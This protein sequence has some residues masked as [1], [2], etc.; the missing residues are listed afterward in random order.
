MATATLAS[1]PTVID[2]AEAITN[3]GGDTFALN[4][5]SFIQGNSSVECAMT[6]NG[7]NDIYVTGSW[8]FSTTDQHLRLWFNITFV[9]NLSATDPIQIFL[10][11]GTNTAYYYWDKFAEY[12][13]GWAQAVIFTGATP[14]SGTVTKSSITRIGMRFAT[15]SKPRNVPY[16]ALFDAWTYGDGYTVYGGTNGDPI[17]WS[18]IATADATNAYGIVDELNGVYF[19]RGAIQIGDGTNTTYFEPAGQLGVFVDEQIE[20]GLYG[21]TFVDS[22]SGVTNIDISGGAWSAGTE[23]YT[24]DA[25]DTDLNAFTVDGLQVSA[26]GAIDFFSAASVTNCSFSDCY[27]INPSTG[28][29]ENN[30]VSNYSEAAVNGALLWPGGTTVKNCTFLNC[31]EAIEIAQTANQ[32]FDGLLFSGNTDDVHLNNGGTD[33]DVSKNNG[34]NPTTY[35]ATGGGVVSFIGS[36]TTITVRATKTDGTPIQ[37]VRVFLRT[38]AAGSLPYNVTVTISNSGT[39][40]TVTHTAHGLSTGDKVVIYGADTIDNLGA[41]AITVTGANTYTFTTTG[42]HSGA[43]T[44]ATIKAYFTYLEGLTDVNGEISASR[45]YPAD[46]VATGTARLSTTA[47]YY[48]PA[49]LNGTVSSTIDVTLVGVMISDD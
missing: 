23:R 24:I 22:V 37:N 2:N 35:V 43:D 20:A 31:D 9:G 46:Q 1:T 32:T 3:W 49:P 8:D 17:D 6:T 36:S 4:T 27:Q 29:F 48:K 30:T 28:T 12:N 39:T 15:A 14:D 13:G 10:Y 18:H 19:L 38:N 47:P 33:I 5:D 42:S 44:G 34:S 40:A 16:N 21:L 25:S 41:K 26:A 11:D 45:V 7:N